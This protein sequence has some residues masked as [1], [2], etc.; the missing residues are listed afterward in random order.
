MDEAMNSVSLQIRRAFND[1]I[2][3][4]VL[5]HIQNALRAGSGQMT[6]KGWNVSAEKPERNYEDNPSQKTRSSSRSEPFRSRVCDE[7]A[8]NAYDR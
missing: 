7:D 3:N 8:D 4:Q 6:Q 5:P 1:A 2:S